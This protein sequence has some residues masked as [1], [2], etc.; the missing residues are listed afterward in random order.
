MQNSTDNQ[1]AFLHS[2]FCMSSELLKMNM[3]RHHSDARFEILAS[4]QAQIGVA[5][6]ATRI[7]KRAKEVAPVGPL[8]VELSD[9]I[10]PGS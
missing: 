8:E 4:S 7:A 1:L 5:K 2:A 9:P 6:T 3:K 10:S